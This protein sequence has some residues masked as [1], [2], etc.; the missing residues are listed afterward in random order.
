MSKC[1]LQSV[2]I[3]VKRLSFSA[4]H[5]QPNE[6]PDLLNPMQLEGSL[7]FFLVFCVFNA[8]QPPARAQNAHATFNQTDIRSC[9]S[10]YGSTDRCAHRA[11]TYSPDMHPVRIPSQ[12]EQQSS[13]S[14]RRLSACAVPWGC[15][16]PASYAGSCF[17][18]DGLCARRQA[19]PLCRR[20]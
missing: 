11:T 16:R 17:P 18:S 14:K 2:S 9:S 3:A 12:A 6:L 15:Q 20:R 8:L 13:R 5:F 1:T 7:C 19:S 10:Q 4:M